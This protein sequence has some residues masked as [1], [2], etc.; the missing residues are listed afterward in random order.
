MATVIEVEKLAL[1]LPERDR[2]MLAANLL[3]SLPP[4]LSDEDEGIT[5]AL[6][7]DAEM[8]ADPSIAISFEELDAEMRNRRR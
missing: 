3:D 2:A 5:E 6:R 7:R 4:I 8:D 1:D